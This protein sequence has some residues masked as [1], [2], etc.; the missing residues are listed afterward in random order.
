MTHVL[1]MNAKLETLREAMDDVDSLRITKPN[2]FNN[3]LYN[4]ALD[5]VAK[6]LADRKR[7]VI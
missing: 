3:V 4:K 7:K 5:D 1:E 2:G 6:L